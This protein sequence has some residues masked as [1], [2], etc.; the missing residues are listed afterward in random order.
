MSEKFQVGQRVR[1]K[2][3]AFGESTEPADVFTR[4]KVGQLVTDLGKDLGTDFEG[5]WEIS[6][7]HW[8]TSVEEDEIEA[9]EE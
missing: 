9:V 6:M 4:G 1:I 7:G 8:T 2:E 3:S 5:C